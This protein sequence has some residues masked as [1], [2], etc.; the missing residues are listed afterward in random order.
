MVSV[1]LAKKCLIAISLI[2][3]QEKHILHGKIT[4]K[5]HTSDKVFGVGDLFGSM[6]WRIAR[7]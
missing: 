4:Q 2:K 6:S 5:E 1:R 3:K 7:I